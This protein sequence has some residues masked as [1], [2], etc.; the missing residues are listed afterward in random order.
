MLTWRRSDSFMC[1]QGHWH[2]DTWKILAADLFYS[3]SVG[4]RLRT[5]SRFDF[6][7]VCRGHLRTLRS[8]NS[9]WRTTITPFH[10]GCA[11][12]DRGRLDLGHERDRRICQGVVVTNGFAPTDS[13][14]AHWS[15]LVSRQLLR[16]SSRSTRRHSQR[17]VRFLLT[18]NS[19]E[20]D[21]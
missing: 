16:D 5:E 11:M 6:S 15:A 17:V 13:Y 21:A 3:C 1:L 9:N 14:H 20:R 10:D 4:V 19:Y 12:S 7:D 18:R 2:E 8:D